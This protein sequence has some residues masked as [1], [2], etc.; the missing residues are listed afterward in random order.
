MFSNKLGGHLTHGVVYKKFKRIMKNIGLPE[1]RFH[2]LR[3]TY[4]TAA[5]Q[6]GDDAKTVQEALGHFSVSF[7]LDTY[8]H[9]TERMKAESASRMERFYEDILK[10]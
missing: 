4:A 5:L 3:H 6:A 1:V 2:D 8:G 10:L 9:I 7:T